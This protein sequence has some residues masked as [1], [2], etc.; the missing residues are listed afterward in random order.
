MN[1]NTDD[2]F[3]LVKNKLLDCVCFTDK[4]Q[5]DILFDHHNLHISVAISSCSWYEFHT[6]A[7]KHI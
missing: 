3:L 4:Q 1:D 7:L 6:E 2:Y 5:S